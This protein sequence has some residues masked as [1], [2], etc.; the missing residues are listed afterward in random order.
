MSVRVASF[1][2]KGRPSSEDDPLLRVVAIA[3]QGMINR[4]PKR[5]F[6][7][8]DIINLLGLETWWF[9]ALERG[10]YIDLPFHDGNTTYVKTFMY[11]RGEGAADKTWSTSKFEGGV[12]TKV[13]VPQ[14]QME[15][16][17]AVAYTF[18]Y[19]VERVGDIAIAFAKDR[20]RHASTTGP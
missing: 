16:V 5:P 15:H 3:I 1:R 2:P 11:S 14:E 10:F 18:P 13:R 9:S 19:A 20:I 12:M 7:A 8:A 6:E 4:S 17:A